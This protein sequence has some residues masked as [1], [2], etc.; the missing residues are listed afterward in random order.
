MSRV[1]YG[2]K[3]MNIPKGDERCNPSKVT[4]IQPA[5]GDYTKAETLAEWRQMK[6]QM[7]SKSWQRKSPTKKAEL[8]KEYETDTGRVA[9]SEEHPIPWKHFLE[10]NGMTHQEYMQLPQW[11]RETYREQY[12]KACQEEADYQEARR[13]GCNPEYEDAM[14]LLRQ[15]GVPFSP[16][17]E[18]LGIGWD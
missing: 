13:A 11:K 18:P 2:N 1:T 14:E 9:L 16:S 6:Y 12:E 17:G 5:S 15:C 3:H 7:T 4:I 8:R 10:V